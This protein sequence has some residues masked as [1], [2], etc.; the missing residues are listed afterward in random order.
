[1]RVGQRGITLTELMVAMAIASVLV[2]TVVTLH[3][4]SLKSYYAA[5]SSTALSQD[6]FLIGEFLRSEAIAAGGGSVRAWMALWVEDNCKSRN[7]LPECRGS[8]RMTVTKISLPEQECAITAQISSTEMRVANR[9]PMQCCLAPAVAGAQSFL[10]RQVVLSLNGTYIQ[11]AVSQ[12]D[13]G[14]CTVKLVPGQAEGGDYPGKTT[15]WTG[16]VLSLVNVATYYMDSSSRSLNAWIDK[17][18]DSVFTPDESSLLV[19]QVFDFQVT[20]GYD[21][22]PVDGTVREDD[23]GFDDEWLYND[24]E[25]VESFGLG[26]FKPPLLRRDLAM[27]QIGVMLGVQRIEAAD[28]RQR[29]FN[30]PIREVDGWSFRSAFTK[31]APRNTF[32]FQ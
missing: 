31:V 12:V 18:R 9:T 5:E 1:M 8:D 13:L 3:L 14:A 28:S 26:Y 15:N 17:N 22:M 4:S 16:A 21:F 10:N 27:V 25:H 23:K 19:D 24:P 11:R 20:L 32:I 29:L 7:S 2:I 30:G 6:T